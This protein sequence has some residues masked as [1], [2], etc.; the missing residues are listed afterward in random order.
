MKAIRIDKIKLLLF[1]L[2]LGPQKRAG[3]TN[4]SCD[5]SSVWFW[6]LWSQKW[7]EPTLK[8]KCATK[9]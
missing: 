7:I 8:E 3:G 9:Q 2:W 5:V 1:W 6:L 4:I